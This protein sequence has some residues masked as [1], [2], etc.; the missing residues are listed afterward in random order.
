MHTPT[1]SKWTPPKQKSPPLKS[2]P[3]I[4]F[5]VFTN[6]NTILLTDQA[7][8]LGVVL[9]YFFLSTFLS[10]PSINPLDSVILYLQSNMNPTHS[11]LPTAVLITAVG[12]ILFKYSQ[13]SSLS[14]QKR[15]NVF[16]LFFIIKANSLAM[17]LY[18]LGPHFLLFFPCSL[19]FSHIGSL[20]LLGYENLTPTSG[21][22][23]LLFPL[24]RRLLP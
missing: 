1:D 22:L 16:P 14:A 18:H 9:D 21:P 23:H 13:F 20:L 19:C 12:M 6:S 17:A 7:R 10:H 11:H 3:H 4:I 5:A 2:V 15:S 8:K 24:S